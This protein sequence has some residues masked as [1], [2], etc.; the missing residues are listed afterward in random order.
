MAVNKTTSTPVS[1]AS[2]SEFVNRNENLKPSSTNTTSVPENKKAILP[3]V[4]RQGPKIP[5]E[6]LSNKRLKSSA[7]SSFFTVSFTVNLVSVCLFVS[8]VEF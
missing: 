4:A 3:P 1:G 5:D 8:Y 2:G 7:V 6:A